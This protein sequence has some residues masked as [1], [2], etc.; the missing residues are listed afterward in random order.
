M[1]HPFSPLRF[2]RNFNDEV[3]AGTPIN[4]VLKCEKKSTFQNR[5]VPIT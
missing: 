4:M 3:Q 1:R 5:E 2:P